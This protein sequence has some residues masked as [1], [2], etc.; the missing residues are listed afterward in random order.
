[1]SLASTALPNSQACPVGGRQQAAQ[2]LHRRRL[3]AAVGAEEAE[4]LT[5]LDPEADMIDRN[6]IAESLRQAVRLDDHLL[7]A[8]RARGTTNSW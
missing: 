5:A 6:E 4:D 8:R 2:H 3:A 1:M 7:L